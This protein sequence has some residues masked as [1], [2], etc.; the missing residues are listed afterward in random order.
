[1]FPPKSFCLQC[2]RVNNFSVQAELTNPTEGDPGCCCTKPHV[3]DLFL[4]AG[5]NL[6]SIHKSVALRASVGMNPGFLPSTEISFILQAVDTLWW[7]RSTTRDDRSLPTCCSS[8]A[9]TWGQGMAWLEAA[10]ATWR[11][12]T[13]RGIAKCK[14]LMQN[15]DK[16]PVTSV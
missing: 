16:A 14:R 1:M 13:G 10:A 11:D 15:V 5:C 2:N 8:S 9:G 7:V 12:S 6:T 4:E 3:Q